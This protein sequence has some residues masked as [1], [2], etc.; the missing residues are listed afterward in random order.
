MNVT[1]DPDAGFCFGVSRAIAAAENELSAG[2]KL[3]CLGDIVHNSE[4]LERL[5]SKGLKIITHDDMSLLSGKKVLIRAHGEPPQT[6]ETAKNL[7][8]TLIDATC[9]IV[10]KLQQRIS[11]SYQAASSEG[12]SILIYGKPGHAEV[13]GLV[14][15]TGGNAVVISKPED[16]DQVDFSKPVHLYSQTTMDKEGLVAVAAEIEKRL[17]SAGGQSL[18]VHNTICGQ[19]S[20]RAP[21]VK[22]FAKKHDVIVFVSGKKSSNGAWLFSLCLSENKRSFFVSSKEELKKDWFYPTDSVG[23]TGATSTPPWLLNEIAGEIS[24]F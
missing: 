16:L 24:T 14:G 22:A 21:L 1:I 19:V 23:V 8:I 9:P 18:K 3:Y 7:N 5:K 6:F 2:E 11:K 4:E 10:N 13:V 17:E 15:Q 20:G 12:S